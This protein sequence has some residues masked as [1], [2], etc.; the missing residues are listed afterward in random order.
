MIF[1]KSRK[2]LESG[3]GSFGTAGNSNDADQLK[4]VT[5]Q[6]L[7]ISLLK[8]GAILM[9]LLGLSLFLSY[10]ELWRLMTP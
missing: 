10:L 1:Q 3:G 5:D 2:G 8:G 9:L 4:T 7:R 6:L